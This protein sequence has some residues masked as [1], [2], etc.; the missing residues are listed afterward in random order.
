MP[1]KEELLKVCVPCSC[2]VLLSPV[3]L[4]CLL[5][6]STASVSHSLSQGVKGSQL[7]P[8]AVL[9]HMY[10]ALGRRRGSIP[11]QRGQDGWHSIAFWGEILTILVFLSRTV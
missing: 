7:F 5:F 8:P 3:P 4:H 1:K 2:W 9:A 11:R 10:V 6:T